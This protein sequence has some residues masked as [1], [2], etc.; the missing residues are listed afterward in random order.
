MGI[1]KYKYIG[2]GMY[3][4]KEKTLI[5]GDLHIGSDTNLASSGALS[6]LLGL[7][8]VKETIDHILSKVDVK[9][10]MLLGDIANNFG[11]LSYQET[12]GIRDLMVWLKEKAEVIVIKGNHDTFV[13]KLLENL[14]IALKEHLT[15]DKF[16]FCHGD[17]IL[18][19]KDSKII[20]IGH[21]HP[22]IK[23]SNGIRSEKFKC[24]IE[25]EYEN[26]KL[27]VLPSANKLTMGT[28]I[29]AEKLLSPYLKKM[30]PKKTKIFVVEDM[31]ILNFGTLKDLS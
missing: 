20:V 22:A 8:E 27:I 11:P 7:T 10:I 23:I 2:L 25:T 18:E 6:P 17:K 12:K 15:I 5:L 13:E 31:N 9:K 4:I 21:E 24:I 14:N 26:K 16:L 29:N 30:D 28:A 19:E 3:M 1:A